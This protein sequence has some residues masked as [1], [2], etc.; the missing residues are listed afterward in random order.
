MAGVIWFY[1]AIIIL[2]TIT[3]YDMWTSYS[4]TAI[5]Y[6]DNRWVVCVI[7]GKRCWMWRE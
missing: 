2:V 5:A 1:I 3:R 4:L 6:G 7:R